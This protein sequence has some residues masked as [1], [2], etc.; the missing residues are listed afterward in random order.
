MIGICYQCHTK[1]QIT[2]YRTKTDSGWSHVS[3]CETCS[4]IYEPKNQA[5][6]SLGRLGGLT[7]TKAKSEASRRNGSKGGRP[8]KK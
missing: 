4:D 2:E 1:K 6:V 8:L 3:L 5:A 7:K